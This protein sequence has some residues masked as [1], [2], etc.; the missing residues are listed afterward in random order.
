MSHPLII[1]NGGI[2]VRD[3]MDVRAVYIEQRDL[4]KLGVWILL[5]SGVKIL[6]KGCHIS[7]LGEA[8]AC[9]ADICKQVGIELPDLNT[10][11][12]DRIDIAKEMQD[13]AQREHPELFI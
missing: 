8:K 9:V 5:S 4:I 2:V 7:K 3:H 1:N 13:L 11:E 10:K 6:V 12:Q